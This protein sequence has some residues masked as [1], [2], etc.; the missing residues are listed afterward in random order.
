MDN[1]ISSLPDYPAL[2]KL[3]FSL[4]QQNNTYHGAAIMV[5]AGFSRC[6]ATTGDTRKKLPLWHDFSQ[7]LSE[8]LKSS[9]KDPLRLAEEYSAFFGKQALYDL[10][11]KE[12]NDVAWCPSE[13]HQ[14]LLKLPWSEVLTTNWDTLLERASL[15]LH[16]RVYSIV[17]KQG[18]LAGCRSPRI[19]KLHGTIDITHELIF[20]QE[21]YRRYPQSFAAFV[22]FSRQVFI[23][24]ELCLLG[25]SGE[26]PNFLQWAGWV[27]DNLATHS[28]R[29]YL[30]GA[31][32][33]S[34]SK[35]KYLESINV[36]PIDFNELVA[37]YDDQD[38]K[39][40]EATKI[41]LQFLEESKPAPTW[42]WQPTQLYH[43]NLT[44]DEFSKIQDVAYGAKILE[45]Q[46]TVLRQD[47]E[48]YPGWLV[49]PANI[50]W[51]LSSQISH[52]WPRKEH[53][54]LM[55][56]D[57]KESLL[58]EMV[59]RLEKAFEIPPLWLTEELLKIC[60]PEVPCTRSKK[61]QLEIALFIFKNT[62]WMEP[63]ESD[64]FSK[65]TKNILEK[66]AHFWSEIHNE[67]IYQQAIFS[68]N[69]FDYQALEKYTH[70]VDGISAIWMLRK[71]A[72]LAELGN[73]HES[74][75]NIAEAHRELL[76]QY[77]NSPNS[78]YIQ[79]RLAWAQWMLLVTDFWSNK[80]YSETISADHQISKCSPW[81]HLENIRKCINK[82][83][84]QQQKKR[85]IEPLFEAGSYRDNAQYKVSNYYLYPQHLL[86]GLS[87]TVGIPIRWGISNLLADAA[88]KL[89]ELEDIDNLHC[90]TLAIRSANSDDCDV[91]N[92]VFS[93]IRIA[94]LPKTDV[95][96]MLS[97]C[98]LAIEYW[99][100]KL[101]RNYDTDQS[102][103]R[104]RLRVFIEVLARVSIRATPEQAT[105]Y[106]RLA[107]S[108]CSKAE[109][110]HLWLK[111]ALGHLLEF[112]LES[113][114]KDQHYNVLPDALSV[115]LASEI[116]FNPSREW[117]NP[118]I[119][120]PGKRLKNSTV[121]RRI[122]AIIDQITPNSLKNGPAL[123]RLLPLI[124]SGFMTQDELSKIQQK[125]WG[126]RPDIEKIP[127]T[128]L[129]P[130]VV[131][132]IPSQDPIG[133]QKL[134]RKYL[135]DVEDESIFVPDRLASI[136]N[137]AVSKRMQ[138]FPEPEQAIDLFNKMMMWRPREKDY[139]LMGLIQKTDEQCAY[140]IG[141]ALVRSVIRSL[142][143]SALTEANF[144]K[145]YFFCKEYHLTE[146]LIAL[147]RFVCEGSLHASV[148]EK[149]LRRKLQSSDPD[150]LAHAS[151]ALLEWRKQTN[152]SMLEKI[153]TR[154]I[155]IIESGQTTG[156]QAK[157]W[158]AKEMLCR[159]FLDTESISSL[160]DALPIIYDSAAY[161]N[162]FLL[163]RESV[164]VSHIRAECIRLAVEILRRSDH[165]DTEL[166]RIVSESKEDALPE[167]RFA[168]VTN[169]LS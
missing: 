121:D 132:E 54:T 98:S 74:E 139:D 120:S 46:L 83:W 106:F 35:R 4:W 20:T 149:I 126:D 140:L 101:S 13:V 159:D 37:E 150:T 65:L 113:I 75:K 80:N 112:S 22:N 129:Y 76:G 52:P 44:E 142:P 117:I 85:S 45:N 158:T 51:K 124:S 105:T 148:L 26:D 88:A 12:V 21:D 155:M 138:E 56:A 34:G 68:L 72:L 23:E 38:T 59:W 81:D 43:N 40:I 18:D 125:V 87:A 78:L 107:C 100:E 94:R 99:T 131:L 90:F 145:L 84:E 144:H 123:E 69:N 47:R 147:P 36:S 96:A 89:T 9:S 166:K 57:C 127:E 10:I 31:L 86:E 122:D 95:E 97:R 111:N 162:I 133:V 63:K 16:S 27:R 157:L 49:C 137:V 135:F 41:F 104:T 164:S 24:N 92:S 93:R 77:R 152:S 116:N 136:I 109:F 11:K 33:L 62:R 29:I 156:L 115:P 128:G 169:D 130:C 14:N 71:A 167:V 67:L 48:S 110:H 30:V 60:N 118:I 64:E 82:E 102:Y 161:T 53:F 146:V 66:G 1:K 73:F 165:Q 70:Q 108:M 7:T 50:R 168:S 141:K 91:M 55:S 160:I 119:H 79:S 61:Q 58:Y 143:Q 153:I 154:F 15:E 134:I 28:R 19:V 25:F 6:A 17:N 103:N 32:G 42:E 114:P 163:S 8:E 151:Y 3:A 39:H 2:K 5:G